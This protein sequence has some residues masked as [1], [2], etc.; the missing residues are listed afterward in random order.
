VDRRRR[1]N[2]FAAEDR[3]WPFDVLER[4]S[5]GKGAAPRIVKSSRLEIKPMSLDDAA[6]QLETSRN[7]FVVFL[8][9]ESEKV[10]VLYKRRDDNYGLIVPEA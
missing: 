10:S 7:G 3:H 4:E 5:V 6:L 1:A 8:D 9:A 2:R